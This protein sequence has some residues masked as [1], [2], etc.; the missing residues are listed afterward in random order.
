M[1]K[2]TI[3]A[4]VVVLLSSS[5]LAQDAD[6]D[7]SRQRGERMEARQTEGETDDNREKFGIRIRELV[8]AGKLTRE[9]AGEL[10]RLAFPEPHRRQGRRGR[11]RRIFEVKDPAEFSELQEHAIFSGPQAGEKITAFKATGLNGEFADKEFDPIANAKGKPLLLFFQDESGVGFRGLAGW[12]QVAT[13]I[14]ERENV[15]L[16][17]CVIFLGDDP[18]KLAESTRGLRR[19]LGDKIIMTVS[20][21]GRDG[22]GQLG[23][24]RNVSMTALLIKDGIVNHNFAFTQPQ[25]TADPHVLGGVADLIGTDRETLN[26]WL[27]AGAAD[28][29]RMRMKRK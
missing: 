21:D 8:K 27:N 28:Q 3:T 22:P 16:H 14:N 11:R 24:N 6:R 7:K 2:T 13:A 29:E 5:L 9:E 20:K 18:T 26:G 15:E 10:F 17:T 19:F 25:L 4:I 1:K 23:L 12:S